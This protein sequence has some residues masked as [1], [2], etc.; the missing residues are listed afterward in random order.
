MTDQATTIDQL[1]RAFADAAAALGDA[2]VGRIGAQDPELAAKVAQAMGH[3]ERLALCMEFAVSETAIRL[4]TIDDYQHV[5][6]IAEV[7]AKRSR[8]H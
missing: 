8:P 3:G 7:P 5:K 2:M 1:A 6:R 4:V